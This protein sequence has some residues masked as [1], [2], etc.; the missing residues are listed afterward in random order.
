MFNKTIVNY[1]IFGIL[2]TV[3]NISVFSLFVKIFNIDYMFSS[4]LAWIISVLFAFITNKVYVFNS[5]TVAYVDILKELINF[6]F[7]RI[8]SL[9]VDLVIMYLLIDIFNTDEIFA[10][11]IAN[12]VVVIMNYVSSKYFTFRNRRS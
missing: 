8:L 1:V 2:T 6:S 10:K 9:G 4:T 5:Q 12:V 3:V 7:F 11:V